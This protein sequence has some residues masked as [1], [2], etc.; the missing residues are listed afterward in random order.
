MHISRFTLENMQGWCRVHRLS[1]ADHGSKT[2]AVI[3]LARAASSSP[4]MGSRPPSKTM[5][6]MT[7]ARC[8]C[9]TRFMQYVTNLRMPR[10]DTFLKA[11]TATRLC[12]LQGCQTSHLLEGALAATYRTRWHVVDDECFHPSTSAGAYCSC[13]FQ[14]R[15]AAFHAGSL[16][17]WQ[18]LAQ[19][20]AAAVRCL[21]Q[22]P[23]RIDGHPLPFIPA[24]EDMC[25]LVGC[26]PHGRH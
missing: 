21:V 16:V 24:T 22:P 17:G 1:I 9:S 2:E 26:A 4:F 11:S 3:Y 12:V 19:L 10:G 20:I 7:P 13:A 5:T 6:G 18:P 23:V 25:V 14:D 15:F 8:S